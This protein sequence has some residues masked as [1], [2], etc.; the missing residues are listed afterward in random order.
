VTAPPA[1][2]RRIGWALGIGLFLLPIVFAWVLL[3]R[4][5]GRGARIAGFGWLVLLLLSVGLILPRY[6]IARDGTAPSDRS[7][8]AKR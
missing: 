3:G 4:G 5:Y 2:G 8:A 7:H 1:A 6:E